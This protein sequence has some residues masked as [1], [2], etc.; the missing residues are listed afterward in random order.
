MPEAGRGAA[1]RRRDRRG[2]GAVRP[3]GRAVRARRPAHQGHRHL[4]DHPRAR[5]GARPDPAAAG[6]ALLQAGRQR[7]GAAADADHDG[8]PGGEAARAARGRPG[9][10]IELPAER[11]GEMEVERGVALPLAQ[12]PPRRRPTR[13][14]TRAMAPVVPD[15]LRAAPRASARHRGA[16]ALGHRRALAR[17]STSGR[18]GA[19]PDRLRPDRGRRR[20]GGR[21]RRRGGHARSTWTRW[22]R[23]R[24]S[25]WSWIPEPAPAAPVAGGRRPVRRPPAARP[26]LLGPGRRGLRGAHPGAL[27]HAAR[28]RADGDHRGGGRATPSTWW[29]P[30][31]SRSRSGTTGGSRWCWPTSGE[32]E[33]FGEMALLSGAP[34]NAIGGGRG[35][36]RGAGLPGRAAAIPG[37]GATRTSSTRSAASTGSGC[38][39][40]RWR[41]ARSSAPSGG[42]TARR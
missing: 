34:R 9:A 1:S 25:W 36:L 13:R 26:A 33:F 35:A 37:A 17:A 39:P 11:A 41:S 4:Q 27:G 32:G 12:P 23:R 21:G 14:E 22:T 20:R 29:P 19:P 6:R 16:A 38:W 2:G 42:K 8:D 40:T 18:G 10:A 30:A 31:A 5:S 15:A 7:G 3:G 24:W 28:R